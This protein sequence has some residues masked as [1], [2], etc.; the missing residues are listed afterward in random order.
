MCVPRRLATAQIVSPGAGLDLLAVE[1][2]RDARAGMRSAVSVRPK[3]ARAG[4][5][6]PPDFAPCE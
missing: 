6:W 2:E 5:A 3:S 4:A 1:L